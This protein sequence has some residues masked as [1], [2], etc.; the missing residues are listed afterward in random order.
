[1]L[2]QNNR[3]LLSLTKK[4]RL[5]LALDDEHFTLLNYKE[6]KMSIDIKIK[7]D[8]ILEID[9]HNKGL[10][11]HEYDGAIISDY[12]FIVTYNKKDS[13]LNFLIPIRSYNQDDLI[14]FLNWIYDYGLKTP[15]FKLVHAEIIK[16]I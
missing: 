8:K 11:Y 10:D 12:Q 14:E 4:G 16:N 6:N 1:M 5:T 2:T 3:R 9:Q 13:T 15:Y 7:I